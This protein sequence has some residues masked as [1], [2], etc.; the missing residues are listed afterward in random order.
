MKENGLMIK[1]MEKEYILIQ[2]VPNIR[3]SGR[4]TNSTVLEYNNGWMEKSMRVSIEM[5]PK[6]DKEH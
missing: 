6:L 3:D 1:Q 2:M 4:M 5:E